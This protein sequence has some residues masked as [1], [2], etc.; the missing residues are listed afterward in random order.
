MKGKGEEKERSGK[1]DG[2]R[3]EEET[4]MES[5]TEKDKVI[6]LSIPTHFTPQKMY[7]LF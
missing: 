4:K 3:A 1:H 6:N 2:K 5:E 7:N